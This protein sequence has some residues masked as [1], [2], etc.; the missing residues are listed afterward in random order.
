MRWTRRVRTHGRR[1]VYVACALVRSSCPRRAARWV[2]QQRQLLSQPPSKGPDAWRARPTRGRCP[3]PCGRAPRARGSEAQAAEP[4]QETGGAWLL[5]V[6]PRPGGGRIPDGLRVRLPAARAERT[7]C[8][9]LERDRGAPGVPEPPVES[10]GADAH[11]QASLPPRPSFVFRDGGPGM[12]VF[13][14]P[15]VLLEIAGDSLGNP[16]G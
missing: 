6:P 2:L 12:T 14:L 1:S 10:P 16:W 7:V 11:S 13:N 8:R 5:S 4:S 15:L 3:G 9:G